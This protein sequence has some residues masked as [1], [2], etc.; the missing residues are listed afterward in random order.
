M[1]ALQIRSVGLTVGFMASLLVGLVVRSISIPKGVGL[2]VQPGDGLDYERH[3]GHWSEGVKV[4][5][6]WRPSTVSSH[7]PQ[8]SAGRSYLGCRAP[9]EFYT[10][11]RS[12]QKGWR[13][14]HC[15]ARVASTTAQISALPPLDCDN[16]KGGP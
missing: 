8:S 5:L 3:G 15:G 10:K 12:Y 9:R 4:G 2:V 6:Y 14:R 13:P 1:L 16:G 7:G 11:Q